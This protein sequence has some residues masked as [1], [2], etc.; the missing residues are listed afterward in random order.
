M[1]KG[2]VMCWRIALTLASALWIAI[3]LIVI[4]IT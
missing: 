4:S 1:K 3:A 2:M